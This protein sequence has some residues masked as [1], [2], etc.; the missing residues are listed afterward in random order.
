MA[1]EAALGRAR[2]LAEAALERA[3][4]RYEITADRVADELA[5]IAF[6]RINDVTD[7]STVEVEG[8]RVQR[9]TVKDYAATDERALAAVAKIRHQPGGGVSVELADKQGALMKLAQLKGWIAD[10]PQPVQQAVIF[11]IER[12]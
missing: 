11:K 2:A 12:S 3:L 9:L 10:K 6:T 7:L 5:R 8:K 4:A 1:V